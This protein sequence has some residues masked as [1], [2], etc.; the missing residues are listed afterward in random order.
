MD[1]IVIGSDLRDPGSLPWEIVERKGLGHPDTLA[2]GIAEAVSKAYSVYCLEKF[3]MILHH[4]VDKVYIGSGY[5]T[6]GF[7]WMKKHKPVKVLIN[8]RMSSEFGGETIDIEKIQTDAATEYLEIIFPGINISEYFEITPNATQNTRRENWFSPKT[9]EDLPE[10]FDLK[11]NDTSVSIAFWPFTVCEELAYEIERY[12]WLWD[13]QKL[14]GPKW[15]DVGS[16]IKVMVYREGSNIEIFVCVPLLSGYY[17]SEGAYSEKIGE[18]EQ[19]LNEKAKQIIGEKEYTV[20]LRVNY[21]SE[22]V[23]Y[24]LLGIGSCIECGEEGIVGR[25]NS[26]SGVISVRRDH[27]ME[28]PFGKNPVYHSGKVL[29]FWAKDLAKDIFQETSF[30]C[31]ITTLTVNGNSLIPPYKI[32][33]ETLFGADNEKIISLVQDKMSDRDYVNKYLKG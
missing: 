24:Y 20:F 14:I 9:I 25:G 19:I 30:P 29:A 26:L 31:H 32:I 28:A 13:D 3:G 15:Q 4:N 17:N 11:A 16:D 18:I 27:S 5:F 33:I 8:G 23:N 10:V 1:N 7:G 22:G 6:S 21:R 12:F 2:D